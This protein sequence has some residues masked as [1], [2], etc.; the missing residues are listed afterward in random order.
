MESRQ[1][2]KS[3]IEKRMLQ[4]LGYF[5][6]ETIPVNTSNIGVHIFLSDLLSYIEGKSGVIQ[7]TTRMIS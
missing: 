3:S 7:N 2:I 6:V 4:Q 5:N 1:N